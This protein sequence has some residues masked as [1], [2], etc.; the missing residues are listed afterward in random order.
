MFVPVACSAC[1]KPFQVPEESIGQQTACPWCR[2]T[3]LALPVGGAPAPVEAAPAPAATAPAPLSLD[4]DVPAR[5]DKP[6]N[7]RRL[8]VPALLV[9]VVALVTIAVLKRKEGYLASR[10][11]RGFTPPDK[12]CSIDLMGSPADD[13]ST[14]SG[15]THRYISEGWYSGITTW[16]AWRDLT[17]A[18]AQAASSDEAWHDAQLLKLFDAERTW[19]KEKF[20]GQL[21]RDATIQFKGPL[22]RELRLV[23]PANG[24]T[25]ERMIVQ[26]GGSHP[27]IYFI[28]MAG[29]RL[30]PEGDK[31]KRLFDSFHVAE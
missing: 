7:W 5:T 15:A 30:D 9:L 3:V 1:G 28:G 14:P 2:A 4:D 13:T 25:V 11:W 24:H 20:D 6:R 26:A 19:L 22:T 31:V 23:M 21:A 16:L 12:S 17:V 29:K 8:L 10:E 27:R 18:E